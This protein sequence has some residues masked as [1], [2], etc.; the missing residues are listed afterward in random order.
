MMLI[1][2]VLGAAGFALLGGTT[3][4]KA[5]LYSCQVDDNGNCVT[6]PPEYSSP[7]NSF[8][9]SLS[10]WDAADG[11]H[12]Y[13][14]ASGDGWTRGSSAY[15]RE[16][17]VYATWCANNGRSQ[18]VSFSF[19]YGMPHGFLCS[20]GTPYTYVVSGGIGSSWITRHYE[21]SYSCT[22]P[23][24]FSISDRLSFNLRYG[25]YGAHYFV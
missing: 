8:T 21:I 15:H 1:A 4:A 16:L 3:T 22:T 9:G 14:T 7:N 6:M 11:R 19:G 18:L 12:C 17:D 25:T 23:L 5:I 2:L 10:G 20:P 13:N 24:G